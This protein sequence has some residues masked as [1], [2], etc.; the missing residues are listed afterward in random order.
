MR[1]TQNLLISLALLLL[2]FS[3]LG[4]RAAEPAA[5]IALPLLSCPGCDSQPIVPTPD[6]STYASEA[7]RLINEARIAAGCPAAVPHPALMQ[8]T[9]EWSEY[10]DNSGIYE[11]ATSEHYSKS[12]YFYK[13][14]LLENI[15]ISGNPLEIVNGWLVSAI[16]RSNIE[17]CDKP[18]EPEY[19]ADRIYDIGVGYS[20]GYWT[21]ALGWR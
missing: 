5:R 13:W 2:A 17:F 16:H 9:Q 7:V 1:R 6:T 21:M 20:N 14:F 10:M 4:A 11:H 19:R 15:G 12:P 8:A 18:G 3:A